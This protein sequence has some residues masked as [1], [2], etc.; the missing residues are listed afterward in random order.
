M[1]EPG[2]QLAEID[3]QIQSVSDRAKAV[4]ERVGSVRASERPAGG[5]WSVADCLAH[6]SLTSAPYFP[7]WEQAFKEMKA[8]GESSQGPFRMDFIGWILAWMM[9][10]PARMRVSTAP[11]FEPAGNITGD[12]ALSDFLAS[13]ATVRRAIADADGLPL[14]RYKIVSPFSEKLRYNVWSSFCLLA[15]HQRR[16]LWQAERVADVLA[17]S[18]P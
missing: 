5:K 3:R 10:P 16:H 4:V 12:R 8:K 7:L 1:R 17:R 11:G 18:Q 15:A 9:E 2:Q 6:L 14:D 13:Q